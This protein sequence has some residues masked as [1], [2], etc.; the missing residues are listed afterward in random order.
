MPNKYFVPVL[1]GAVKEL[2]ESGFIKE[3]FGREIPAIIHGLE[4][5]DE[6]A[7][8]NLEANP[9]STIREFATWICTQ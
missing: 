8:I 3:K 5:Y 7:Q 4:Y 1:I 9:E 2:H 6:V